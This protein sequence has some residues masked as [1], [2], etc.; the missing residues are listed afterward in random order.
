MV[1][2][3]RTRSKTAAMAQSVTA[4]SHST[5]DPAIDM[6]APP[7]HST[8]PPTGPAAESS[9]LRGTATEHGGTSHQG[10]LVTTT[11]L[12]PVL[13]QLQ[14]FPP[15]PPRSTHALGYISNETLARV[16]L[17]STHFSQPD[18]RSQ[19]DHNLRVDQLAQRMDDQNALIRQLINQISVAQNLVLGQ[20]GEERRIDERTGGQLNGHQAGRAGVSRQRDAQ[21]RDQLADMSQA[22]ASHTQSN[23]RERLGP[24]LDVRARLGPQGNVLQRLGPQEGQPDNRQN[25]DREGRRSVAHS[26]RN[27]HERL[28]PQGGQPGNPRNEDREERNSI[29]TSRRTNSRRQ[30]AENPSQTQSTNT[31]PRQRGR[32]DRPSRTNEEVNQRC[33]NRKSRQRDRPA[34]CAEDVEK[35]VNDRL[36][37]LKTGGNLEDALRKEMDQAISTPFTP[38]IEQAAPPRRFSTPSFT[39]FKGDSD[40][41]SHL[42]HFKSVMILHKA[43]D[44]LMCK[45]V[46]NDLARSSSGL[47]PHLAIRVDQ[48]FQ[49]ACLCLH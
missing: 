47:V 43:D 27:V 41:E 31:P 8:V 15:L 40:P 42:K 17:G 28:G 38:E 5:H 33:P 1:G 22:S 21:P 39:H 32:E 37:D 12:G 14:V 20:P 19:A 26:Q 25:E 4:Q 49:G 30:A 35:L 29:A 6:V 13:E 9:N 34:I 2:S 46:C 7:P 16:Q 23:V 10:G 45:G 24:R 3:K 48:Q 18:P 36:R 44:A 11:D